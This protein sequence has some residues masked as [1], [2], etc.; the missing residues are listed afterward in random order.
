MPTKTAPVMSEEEYKKA[1]IAQAK[2]DFDN[3][4]FGGHKNPSYMAMKN[5]FVSVASPNR[6]GAI[7]QAFI[8]LP[9]MQR[10]KVNYL[11]VKDKHGNEI[12]SFSPAKGWTAVGTS[13]E[14]ARESTFDSI[15]TE[16]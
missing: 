9:F 7:T 3:G 6:K 10:N 5:S 2:K 1:I 12:A 8:S 14:H 16:A 4:K 11:Q 13:A 15:Y